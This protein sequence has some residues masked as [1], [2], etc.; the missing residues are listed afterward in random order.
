MDINIRNQRHCVH[1][2]VCITFSQHTLLPS[3]VC[4]V[5]ATTMK[6]GFIIEFYNPQKIFKI[7][8]YAHFLAFF[9]SH[10]LPPLTQNLQTICAYNVTY[11]RYHLTCTYILLAACS[12]LLFLREL[13]VL[14]TPSLLELQCPTIQEARKQTCTCDKDYNLAN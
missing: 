1:V 12:E 2:S 8:K 11:F 10:S 4:K 3:V 7:T 9:L 5:K 6:K 14:M 13:P